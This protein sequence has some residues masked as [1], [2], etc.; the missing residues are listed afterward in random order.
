MQNI[1]KRNNIQV[2]GTGTR[3]M[4]MIHGFGCD[5]NMWRYVVPAFKEK[6]KIILLDLVG[7]GMSDLSAY[8]AVKYKTLHGYA[9]DIVEICDHLNLKN[10][11][12]VGHSVS[13]MICT[14]AHVKRPDLFSG[15]IMVG[16]SPRYINDGDYIGGFEKEDI[17]DL[18]EMMDT[19]YLGWSEATAPAI[20]G[21][22]ETPALGAEL[23]NSFCQ[24]DPK[25]ARQFAQATF[26]SDNR[27]DIL[28]IEIPTLI[29]QCSE[30]IIAP[31]TVG[32]YLKEHIRNNKFVHLNATGHCPH[33]S[34][35][36]ETIAAMESWLVETG[37]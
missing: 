12:L 21:N 23:T 5:Q 19:N 18:I 37:F 9:E 25:I 11:I 1:I 14:L 4:I 30:D 13:A 35:P 3:P 33:M 7:T 24:I 32:L 20:M 28:K 22:P 27:K 15:M 16:P 17:E 31:E 26:Y 6:Y 10:T 29:L 34:A 8:D 2:V 36:A